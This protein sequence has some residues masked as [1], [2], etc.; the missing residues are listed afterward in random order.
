MTYELDRRLEKIEQSL[1][2]SRE[3]FTARMAEVETKVDSTLDDI[4][5]LETKVERIGLGLA[6]V[7]A[8]IQWGPK[9]V[10]GAVAV[11]RAAGW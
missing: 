7:M 4:K 1:Y 11:V 2:T 10:D 9:I 8:L 5:T 3:S 6:G